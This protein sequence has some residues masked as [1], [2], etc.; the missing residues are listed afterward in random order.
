MEVLARD[1]IPNNQIPSSRFNKSTT[2][3]QKILWSTPNLP[4]QAFE[5]DQHQRLAD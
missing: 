4:G 5:P 3:L 1:P 2:D